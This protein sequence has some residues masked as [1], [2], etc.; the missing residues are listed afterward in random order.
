[1]AIDFSIHRITQAQR[2][3]S[4]KA[5][6]LLLA[7][8]FLSVACAVYDG[9]SNNDNGGSTPEQRGDA[10]ADRHPFSRGNQDSS[11]F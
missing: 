8:L 10:D 5:L 9:P 2:L 6:L 7:G 3:M 4:W 1:M 11:I